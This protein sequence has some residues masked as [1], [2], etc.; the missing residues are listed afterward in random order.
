MRLG[1][2]LVYGNKLI[3]AE[4]GYYD[5]ASEQTKSHFTSGLNLAASGDYHGMY[6][7]GDLFP[8]FVGGH[9]TQIPAEW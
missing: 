2:L 8:A 3:G 6:T 5:G 9:M 7:V 4:W 1:G